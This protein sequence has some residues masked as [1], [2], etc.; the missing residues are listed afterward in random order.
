MRYIL[1]PELFWM[2]AYGAA[3]LIAKANVPPSKSIDGFIDKCWFYV[4]LLVLV[5]FALWWLPMVEKRWLL[6]R[7]WVAS[8][9]G[10]HFVLE[11]IM[12]AYSEQG[13][14]IGTAYLVGL[15]LLIFWLIAG[16]VFVL[17]KC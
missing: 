17:I 16:T 3:Q 2:L 5:C 15:I 13:P 10:G 12:G 8:I 9:L 11:K 4:P 14:G 6:P 7:V 1:G